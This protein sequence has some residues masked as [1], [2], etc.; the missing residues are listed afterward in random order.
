MTPLFKT[1]LAFL[2]LLSG[3]AG[4][5]PSQSWDQANLKRNDI[6]CPT[7]VFVAPG[8]ELVQCQLANAPADIPAHSIMPGYVT[9]DEAAT[10]GLTAIMQKP[11][12]IWYEGGGNIIRAGNGYVPL[13]PNTSFAAQHVHIDDAPGLIVATFHTHVCKA[14]FAHEYFSP[15]DMSDSIF[16]HITSYMGDVCTGLVHKFTKTDKPDEQRDNGP[17]VSQGTIIGKFTTPHSEN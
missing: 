9:I 8:G 13:A 5:M 16:S 14:R 4:H 10:A 15:A 7:A 6:G 11:G 1:F 17:W 12:A 3:C 2:V